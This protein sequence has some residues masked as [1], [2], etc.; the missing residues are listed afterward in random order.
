[1]W[2]LHPSNPK[3][4]ICAVAV[5][6]SVPGCLLVNV[7]ISPPDQAD[8]ALKDPESAELLLQVLSCSVGGKPQG[9][10]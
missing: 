9:V 3:E 8:A 4:E 7:V 6:P 1:M 2:C 10:A 5:Q